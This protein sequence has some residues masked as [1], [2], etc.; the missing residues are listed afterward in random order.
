[1]R[2]KLFT[3]IQINKVEIKNRLA[4]APIATMGLVEPDGRYSQRAIDYYEEI[5]KGGVGLIISGVTRVENEIDKVTFLLPYPKNSNM[6]NFR[7]LAEAIH[8]YDAK[9]FVQLTAGFGRNSPI[10]PAIQPISASAV[11]HYHNPSVNC[12]ALEIEEIE[13]LVKAFGDVAEILIQVGVDGIELHGHEGY[14]LDQFTTA[15]WNKRNDKYGGSLENRLRFPIEILHEI[16]NKVGID[17]PVQYRYGLKHYLKTPD[18]GALPDEV[19]EEFGRDVTESIEMAKILEDTGFDALHFDAGGSYESYYWAHPPMYMNH[20]VNFESILPELKKAVNIPI[21]VCSRFDKPDL[22]IRVVSDGKSDMVVIGRGLL[23]DPHWP[24]KVQQKDFANIRP[25]IACNCCLSRNEEGGTLACAVNPA[26]GREKIWQLQ[27]AKEQKDV[28]VCGGGLA[29]M[30][31]ARV[32]SI[33]G[34]NVLLCEKEEELGGHLIEGSVLDVKQDIRKL[35]DWYR[36]QIKKLKVPVIFNTEVTSKFV[37]ERQPHAVIFATGSQPI[38]PNL[39]GIEKSKVHIAADIL[40]EKAKV[41]DNIVVVGGSYVGCEVAFWLKKLGKEVTIIEKLPKMMSDSPS[42]SPNDIMLLDMLNYL[43]VKWK[44]DTTLLRVTDK[45]ID[46]SIDDEVVESMKCDS[47]V[48]AVGYRPNN[49]LAESLGNK[50]YETYRI[51]D[52][53]KPR[54]ILNAIWEAYKIANSI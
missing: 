5:A 24:R 46:V 38:I 54:M 6:P 35:L 47:V 51:G 30:E 36:Q 17:F 52:C 2:E 1:M 39:P 53:K 32:L 26:A 43:G 14:L 40:L 18:K 21:L 7:E 23:A 41:L 27:F 49:I 16:K 8:Y 29:G 42:H 48:L 22:A 4:L 9:L 19:F 10:Q 13:S 33:R 31:A 28:L 45:G 11:P 25:C 50:G 44:T 34:H 12:R 20:G 3:P 15:L 37:D